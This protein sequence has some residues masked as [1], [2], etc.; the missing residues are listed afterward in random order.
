MLR[1][2]AAAWQV[3][4]RRFEHA[5]RSGA[6]FERDV[7]GVLALFDFRQAQQVLDDRVQPI[8]LLGDD[9]QKPLGIDRVVASRRRAAFRRSP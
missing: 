2:A 9:P 1:S 8:G 5:G 7:V 6:G 3:L 4:Q